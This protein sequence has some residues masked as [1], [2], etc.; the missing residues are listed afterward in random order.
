MIALFQLLKFRLT[1]LSALSAAAAYL[2]VDFET[3]VLKDFLW[4]MLAVFLVGGGSNAFNMVIERKFDAQMER[5]RN[6]PL[7]KESIAVKEALLWSFALIISGVTL[8]FFI[9][10]LA[11]LIALLTFASYVLVYTPLK[12]VTSLC[13]LIGA[14]PG[15]LPPLIGYTVAS[16]GFLGLE[17]LFLALIIFFWQMPHFLAISWMHRGDYS[18]AGYPML[19]VLDDEKGSM[20]GRQILVYSLALLP[21]SL[22]PHLYRVAGVLYFGAALTLGLIFVA[23]ALPF[24]K[25]C[26]RPRARMMFIYSIV[27]LSFLMV[28]WVVDKRCLPHA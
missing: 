13:T 10:R 19:S 25:G 12:R 20:T 15:A 26:S 24:L 4:A 7:V 9:E 5:T 17:A 3:F 18:T 14:V 27:Y 2:L 6:R 28:V 21:I 16:K 23:L 22:L 1:F 11:S 8:L